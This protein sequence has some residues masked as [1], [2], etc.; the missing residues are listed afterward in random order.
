VS[1]LS[2]LLS[3]VSLFFFVL[4]SP[5]LSPKQKKKKK[6]S[7]EKEVHP[8]SLKGINHVAPSLA[9]RSFSHHK[10]AGFLCAVMRLLKPSLQTS[11]PLLCEEQDLPG[12]FFNAGGLTE[13]NGF[14]VSQML[15]LPHAFGYSLHSL[16]I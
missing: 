14:G 16:I 11:V 5:F 2:L 3:F 1:L 10:F 13:F 7:L 8:I 9:T 4:I 12:P 6:Q 15:T